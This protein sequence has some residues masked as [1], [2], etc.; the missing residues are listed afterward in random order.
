LANSLDSNNET[1]SSN[2]QEREFKE[3]A[4]A[5]TEFSRKDD[6]LQSIEKKNQ[7]NVLI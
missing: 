1:I 2:K 7:R 6:P 4:G 3:D 5:R